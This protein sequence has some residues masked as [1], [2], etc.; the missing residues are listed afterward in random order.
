MEQGPGRPPFHWPWARHPLHV[1]E[2]PGRRLGSAWGVWRGEHALISNCRWIRSLQRSRYLDWVALYSVIT[3][4]NFRESVECWDGGTYNRR[5]G[6]HSRGVSRQ[7]RSGMGR[8]GNHTSIP[9]LTSAQSPTSCPPIL[10]PNRRR[11]RLENEVTRYRP[12]L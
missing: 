7:R 1:E 5:Q 4:T 2:G 6:A 3:S 9:T 10:R 8:R 12:P 11:P